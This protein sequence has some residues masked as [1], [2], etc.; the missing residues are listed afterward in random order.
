[1]LIQIG[2]E[3]Y[4]ARINVNGTTSFRGW[5]ILEPSHPRRPVDTVDITGTCPGAVYVAIVVL[6][7]SIEQ[8][9]PLVQICLAD[10]SS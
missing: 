3:L 7:E 10:C 2:K 1:M 4:Y 9:A 5:L 8:E 6:S